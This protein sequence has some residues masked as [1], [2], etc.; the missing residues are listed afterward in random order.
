MVYS[1]IIYFKHKKYS[2]EHGLESVFRAIDK[3][4]SICATSIW[5]K[6]CTYNL[7][8]WRK[9]FSDWYLIVSKIFSGYAKNA[10]AI[11]KTTSVNNTVKSGFSYSAKG[12]IY[13]YSELLYFTL[14]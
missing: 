3:Q 9:G 12:Q 14:H 4:S 5:R 11:K 2:M 7:M 10:T 13:I 8:N 6:F 1:L